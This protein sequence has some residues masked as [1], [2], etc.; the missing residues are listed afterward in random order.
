M[1]LT[2]LRND[3]RILD[4]IFYYLAQVDEIPLHAYYAVN[5]LRE[6]CSV[7]PSLQKVCF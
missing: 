5:I 6:L 7:R 1:L 2:P 3:D 4:V